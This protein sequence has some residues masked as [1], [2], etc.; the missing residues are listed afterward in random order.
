MPKGPC[1]V[2]VPGRCSR[3]RGLIPAAPARREH[4]HGPGAGVSVATGV[5]PPAGSVNIR[6]LSAAPV[7]E[8]VDA[9]DS[10]SVAR[11]GVL[12]QVRPGAPPIPL[13][14]SVE[15]PVLP[16]VGHPAGACRLPAD[17]GTRPAGRTHVG[18]GE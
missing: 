6:P 15:I 4:R 7:V 11:K 9:T 17:G 18:E 3:R 5:A 1:L 14:A 2:H 16:H 8:L 12:V 13:Y 10:K